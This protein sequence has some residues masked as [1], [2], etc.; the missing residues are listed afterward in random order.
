MTDPFLASTALVTV[1][2]IGDKTQLLSLM[3][4]ARY[5]KPLP[6]ILAIF[7]ATLAN[8]ALAAYFGHMLGVA[9]DS[10]WF[11]WGVATTF[12][13]I[14]LWTLIPDTLE[15]KE[16]CGRSVFMATLACFFFAE[17]GDKTQ[18]ATIAL[19][20]EY[21]ALLP[22]VM[23][24]TLGMMLANVP[25]VLLGE[26]LMKRLPLQAVR[27]AASALFMGFGLYVM[28]ALV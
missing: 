10:A 6:I 16:E 9:A 26:R 7:V 18:L 8:H 11:R 28:A 23:G 14:G 3:L 24:T 25:V 12:I 1:A 2:E 20:A 21:T 4:A 17:M 22:V 13:A 5:R 15:E 19:G 27:Y